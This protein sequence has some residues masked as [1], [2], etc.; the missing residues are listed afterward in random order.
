MKAYIR[1]QKHQEEWK[2]VQDSDTQSENQYL[3]HEDWN[4]ISEN[5]A[6]EV[7]SWIEADNQLNMIIK[8]WK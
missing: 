5:W 2:M 8:R 1:S 3:Q 7:Q 6:R 4:K